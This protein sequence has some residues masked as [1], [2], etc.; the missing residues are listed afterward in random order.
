MQFKIQQNSE[1]SDLLDTIFASSLIEPGVFISGGVPRLLWQNAAWQ[2]H[3]VDCFFKNQTAFDRMKARLDHLCNTKSSIVSI[4]KNLAL[5]LEISN[6]KSP[7]ETTNA[8]TYFILF[9][10]QEIKVQ[11]IKKRFYA[12]LLELWNDFDFTVCQFAADQRYSYASNEAVKD[13]EAKQLCMIE[14]T[15]RPIKAVRVIKYGIYGFSA[16][17]AIMQNLV[18]RHLAGENLLENENGNDDIEY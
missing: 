2:T 8:I 6:Q 18:T 13:C 17:T 16:N 11:L 4:I 1:F 9:K 3:D 7:F 15:T 14:N 5:D 10:D 12:S